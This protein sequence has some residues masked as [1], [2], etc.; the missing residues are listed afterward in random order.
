MKTDTKT[1]E[2]ICPCG[3]H[4]TT[5]KGST[6]SYCEP[7]TARRMVELAGSRPNKDKPT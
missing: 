2:R 1:V 7:C 6:R 3:K 5:E 4:F